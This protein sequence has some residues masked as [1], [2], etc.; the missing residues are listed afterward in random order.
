M[1]TWLYPRAFRC[2]YC[3]TDHAEHDLTEYER[4]KWA[5]QACARANDEEAA[6]RI[7]A[8]ER[9]VKAADALFDKVSGK[10]VDYTWVEALAAYEAA[11]EGGA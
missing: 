1:V 2:D 10:Y 9:Q 5:C 3:E 6:D 8:L 11:K 4:N 7:D